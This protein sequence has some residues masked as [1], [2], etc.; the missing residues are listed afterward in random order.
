MLALI[1]RLFAW[2]DGAALG[3]LWTI[4]RDGKLVGEDEY[5]NRYYEERK[6]GRGAEGRPRRW[7]VYKGF[8]DASRVPSDW[9]GW[10]HHTFDQP[11]TVE[12]LPRRPWEIDH[13]PNL[14]G[15]L[16]AY[17]PTGSLAGERKRQAT[18]AD[19]EAWTPEG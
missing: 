9:H 7:V 8:A 14:T 16:H 19:Y 3:A 12:P 4:R 5:G 1:G 6:A 2:W 10:M 15:T 17:R 18:S 11:P 13:K